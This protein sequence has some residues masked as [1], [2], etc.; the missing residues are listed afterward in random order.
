M[1]ELAGIGVPE[2]IRAGRPFPLSVEIDCDGHCSQA[3]V[4]VA[5]NGNPVATTEIMGGVGGRFTVTPPG[6]GGPPLTPAEGVSA[7]DGSVAIGKPGKHTLSVTVGTL[8][9]E[10]EIMVA[11][12]AAQVDYGRGPAENC[13]GR[14]G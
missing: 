7:S 11:P 12:A 13:G 14:R 10:R 4:I 1:Y 9:V 6:D 8:H 5:I 3:D 2:D